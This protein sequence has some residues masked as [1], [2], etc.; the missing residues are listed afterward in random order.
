MDSIL[1]I[2]EKKLYNV[3]L[4][5]ILLNSMQI[6]CEASSPN[7]TGGILIGHYTEDNNTAIITEFL[8]A[9][10][11]SDSGFTWFYRGTSGVI[12]KLNT[13]WNEKRHYYIGEWHYHPNSSSSLSNQDIKQ[14]KSISKIK[15]YNCPEP[16]LLIIGGN[17]SLWENSVYVFPQGEDFKSLYN[18]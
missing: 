10:S 2:D 7:E 15:S 12:Q 5:K 18:K 16:I 14:M 17:A 4:S 3:C 8:T 1:Y 6:L 13:I 9:P 11:D